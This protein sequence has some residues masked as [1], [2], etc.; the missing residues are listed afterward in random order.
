MNWC[1]DDTEG[2]KTKRG[3]GRPVEN[4]FASEEAEAEFVRRGEAMLR[5]YY[6]PTA[7]AKQNSFVFTQIYGMTK[8]R[9]WSFI[10]IYLVSTKRIKENQQ[11]YLNAVRLHFGPAV[12]SDRTSICKCVGLL[13]SLDVELEMSCTQSGARAKMQQA[14]RSQYKYVVKRWEQDI[15]N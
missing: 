8:T 12:I 4:P 7:S 15:E 2:P 3:V 6:V 13:Q 11:G 10:Y 1:E 9:F 5:R 14:Y